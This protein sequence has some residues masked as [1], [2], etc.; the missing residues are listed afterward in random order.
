MQQIYKEFG[1]FIPCHKCIDNNIHSSS[2]I[3]LRLECNEK[4][5]KIKQL[6]TGKAFITNGY[7]LPSKYVIHTVRTN[8]L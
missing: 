2:G 3:K 6:E 7:N 4:M 8:N 1:C 5:K